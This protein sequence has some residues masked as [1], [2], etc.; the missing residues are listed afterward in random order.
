[1]DLASIDARSQPEAGRW[2]IRLCACICWTFKHWARLFR[3]RNRGWR[4][5]SDSGPILFV[6][7]GRMSLWNLHRRHLNESQRAIVGARLAT[8][9]RGR[10]ETNTQICAFSQNDAADLLKVS[11]RSVQSARVVLDSG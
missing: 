9:E 3:Q 5:G 7:T 1:M 10:P 6:W 8:L 4:I 2:L 11:H